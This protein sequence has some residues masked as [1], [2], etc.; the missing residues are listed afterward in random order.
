M[1]RECVPPR[2]GGVWGGGLFLKAVEGKLRSKVFLYWAGQPGYVVVCGQSDTF[3]TPMQ[4]GIA[5]LAV[6]KT[7]GMT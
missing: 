4:G 3:V 5:S 1:F 6:F 2:S 7:L